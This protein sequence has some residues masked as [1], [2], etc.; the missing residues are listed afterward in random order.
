MVQFESE[1]PT[2][3]FFKMDI[4][5]FQEFANIMGIRAMPTFFFYIGSQKVDEVVGANVTEIKGKIEMYSR[6]D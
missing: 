4:D 1:Y 6:D 2:V 3:K 5:K